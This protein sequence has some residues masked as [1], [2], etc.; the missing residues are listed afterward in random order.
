MYIILHHSFEDKI[1]GSWNNW[2]FPLYIS[3]PD[4]TIQGYNFFIIGN[5]GE[6]EFKIE[7]E[8]KYYCISNYY[9][10]NDYYENNIVY[11]DNGYFKNGMFDYTINH[12]YLQIWKNNE[13]F[14]EGEIKNG[15]PHGFGT[16]YSPE[17][18]YEGSYSN[19]LKHGQGRFNY[20]NGKQ[21]E[22][23]YIN[24]ILQLGGSSHKAEN[25]MF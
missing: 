6:I 14:F 18:S 5:V 9:K 4:F 3:F 22:N 11:F 10:R 15:F 2:K 7:N 12:N 25:F 8:K 16:E 20:K 17:V 13:K 19:G 24:N 21:Q 1:W 23:I